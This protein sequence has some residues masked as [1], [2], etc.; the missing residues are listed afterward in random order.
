MQLDK[1]N[2]TGNGGATP[3]IFYEN[4]NCLRHSIRLGNWELVPDGDTLKIKPHDTKVGYI[5][6]RGGIYRYY[7]SGGKDVKTKID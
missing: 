7:A 2:Y 6:E 1:W 3:I 4:V 5:F